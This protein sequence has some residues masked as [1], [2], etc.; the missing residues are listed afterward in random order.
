MLEPPPEGLLVVEQQW[1]LVSAWLVQ[2][3][4]PLV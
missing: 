1:L 4:L 3:V 2:L